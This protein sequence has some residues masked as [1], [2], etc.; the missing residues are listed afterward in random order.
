VAATA[1]ATY[2]AYKIV[3]AHGGYIHYLNPRGDS[4]KV[5][6]DTV[7]KDTRLN[8]KGL[9][10]VLPKSTLVSIVNEY[11]E[12]S[13]FDSTVKSVKD[14][15]KWASGENTVTNSLSVINP[16][17]SSI[18]NGKALSE[19]SQGAIDNLLST[20]HQDRMFNCQ[21]CSIAYEMNRRGIKC[22]ANGRPVGGLW[23][24]M[25]DVFKI[26]DKK[27]IMRFSGG[28]KANTKAIIKAFEKYGS[29]AR[30]N[31]QVSWKSGGAHSI[32]WENINGKFHLVDAQSGKTYTGFDDL[33]KFFKTTKGAVNSIRV[34]NAEVNWSSEM[35][36]NALEVIAN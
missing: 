36:L 19:M 1:I 17:V 20:G 34:D 13:R 3:G 32:A 18:T 9:N 8:S 26:T 31:L 22:M 25:G 16:Q 28:D 12:V 15:P 30:G 11:D 24:Q 23:S 4:S 2:A 21:Y 5:L 33:D 29:G 10:K 7:I 6:Y 27:A 14:L 35:L